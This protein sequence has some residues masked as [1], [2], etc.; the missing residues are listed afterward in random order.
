MKHL[1]FDFCDECG[2]KFLVDEL[3]GWL[4]EECRPLSDSW[5]PSELPDDDY[6]SVTK[7]G[8]DQ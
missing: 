3:E 8:D 6:D 4:C 1:P 7:R 2:R 5:K